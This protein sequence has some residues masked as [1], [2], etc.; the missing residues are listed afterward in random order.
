MGTFHALCSRLLSEAG[1]PV[2]LADTGLQ[3]ELAEQ[4]RKVFGLN[5]S[6]DAFLREVS[7]WKNQGAEAVPPEAISFYQNLLSEAGV[8]DYDDLLLAGQTLA[9][10]HF[11][12][13]LVDEFQD[14]NPVQYQLVQ[15]W[16]RCGEELFVI[17][18]PDQSIYGFR[19]SDAHCFAR[20]STD[21]PGLRQITLLQNYRSTPEILSSALS[22]IS[23]NP[24]TPRFLE[25]FR[26]GGCPIRLAQAPGE[27]A[28]AIFIAKEINRLVGGIDML[29]TQEEENRKGREIRGFGEV[30]VLYRTHRQARALEDCLRQEG[31]PYLVAG[32]ED[33]LT[34]PE[35][36]GALCFFRYLLHPE[37][38]G[39]RQ[40]A[41]RLLW[42]GEGQEAGARL[43]VL[44]QHY[45][46]RIT[47]NK[48]EKLLEEWQNEVKV[49][50][51]EAFRRLADM[52]VLHPTMEDFLETLTF[53]EEGDVRRSGSR[54]FSA[55]AVTLMTFHGSKGL[56][57]PVVFLCGARKGL[58]PLELEA[59]AADIE[60]ERRLFF[61]AMTRARDELIL[62]CSGPESSFLG[63]LDT[64]SLVRE[65]VGWEPERE[66]IRQ[67]SLFDFL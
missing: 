39:A 49:E 64:R 1:H 40:L 18:D 25:A 48:P 9:S 65:N 15:N 43:E 45:Q 3:R 61:V 19:G 46:K 38:T 8:Q 54:R 35:V 60:E 27:K 52:S 55:D 30:A 36:R 50:N 42:P 24:G 6:G 44:V 11:R 53:G 16:N 34:E 28:E 2:S 63:E 51:P 7:R 23:H 31:I 37:D 32:R 26:Q 62:T 17:G 14:I 58:T 41:Q 13:L 57:F 20:L 67:L 21:F 5:V 10:N 4:T 33:F 22:L 12:F 56:E 66:E 29:G 47:R 59:E